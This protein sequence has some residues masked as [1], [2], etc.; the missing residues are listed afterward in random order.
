MSA[1]YPDV[2]LAGIFQAHVCE[3]D[4]TLQI[5]VSECRVRLLAGTLALAFGPAA[6][7]YETTYGE[8]TYYDFFGAYA[9]LPTVPSDVYATARHAVSRVGYLKDGDDRIQV[10]ERDPIFGDPDFPGVS[11]TTPGVTVGMRSTTGNI[12]VP[13]PL[14]DP[15]RAKSD[16]FANHALAATA[17]G[18][19]FYDDKNTG[20]SNDDGIPNNDFFLR[21]QS[22]SRAGSGWSD[23]WQ[24]TK[25]A[26]FSINFSLDGSIYRS[27]CGPNCLIVLPAG[28]HYF[29]AEDPAFSFDAIMAVF[30]LNT[31][32]PCEEI[33]NECDGQAD[34]PVTMASVRIRGG[35]SYA[36]DR[37]VVLNG[38][39]LDIDLT[40]S[41]EFEVL[42]GHTYLIAGT[43]VAESDNGGVVDLFNT[44]GLDSVIAPPGSLLSD[45]VLNQGAVLNVS[46][47]PVPGA[48]WLLMGGLGGLHLRV[49]QGRL[50]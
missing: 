48:L 20:E 44:F 47:V 7:A 34:A 35:N 49:R 32:A 37:D 21:T 6:L 45:A 10:D 38:G 39:V 2:S 1:G 42:A 50:A 40:G 30:D 26:T 36:D 14:L 18:Y 31:F 15:A 11:T 23:T 25:D 5:Y 19:E 41:L 33:S 8:I 28:T 12:L 29:R 9:P 4:P 17:Q 16:Y 46:A 3:G 24:A 13:G 27:D 43:V 22:S